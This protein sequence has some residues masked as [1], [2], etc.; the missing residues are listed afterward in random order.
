MELEPVVRRHRA[1][2][3]AAALG[4]VV[5]LAV[6][7]FCASAPGSVDHA[8]S[9]RSA[10]VGT[11]ATSHALVEQCR[12]ADLA[13]G[14]AA[15]RSG[16]THRGTPVCVAGT[17]PTGADGDIQTGHRFVLWLDCSTRFWPRLDGPVLVSAAHGNKKLQ[18]RDDLWVTGD[19]LP[20]G[21]SVHVHGQAALCLGVTYHWANYTTQC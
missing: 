14:C 3:K 5:T 17:L 7:H 6:W 21:V 16:D 11:S 4:V 19:T 18:L 2:I 10:H 8:L 20:G 15:L 1:R 9:N 12:S 13:Y